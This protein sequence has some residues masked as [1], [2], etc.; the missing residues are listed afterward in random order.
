MNN[1]SISS[2]YPK[3]NYRTATVEGLEIFY[4]EAGSPEKP[5]VVLL[6]GFPTS[7]HMFRELIPA[8]A[9]GYHVIAP[10]YPGFGQ[11]SA[12]DAATFSYTF[13]RLAGVME[14]FLAQIGCTRF[15]LYLQDYG[16][17]VGFRIATAHTDWVRGL[18]IQNANAYAEGINLAAFAP[19]QP[20]WAKRTPETEGPVREFLSAA[21][22]RFQYLHG[23]R[24][25]SAVSPDN[26]LHD[27]ALLD[28]PGNDRIQLALLQDYQN[29]LLRYPE[30]QAWLRRHQP[31]TLIAWGKNDPFFTEAG[32]RAYLKDVPDAELHLLDTGH[33]A[34]EEDGPVIATLIR[35]FLAR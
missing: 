10:D 6:H 26:W 8:L 19:V 13:E 4:R 22:T 33:F 30:W 34:L 23:V 14:K 16:A 27:Q 2:A 35:D 5:S 3:T 11:S 18:I 28:R 31:P 7:S 1:P 15:A 12:P 17:P 21:T 29:N 9:D 32:A 20:F 24:H 25:P